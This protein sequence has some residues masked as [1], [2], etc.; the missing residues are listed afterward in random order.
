MLLNKTR[1]LVHCFLLKLC[2]KLVR[3]TKRNKSFCYKRYFVLVIHLKVA[4]KQTICQKMLKNLKKNAEIE[5]CSRVADNFIYKGS[6]G[7]CD[8]I[9]ESL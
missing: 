9:K 5:L 7:Y 8:T 1:H 4:L 6:E 3:E 2:S